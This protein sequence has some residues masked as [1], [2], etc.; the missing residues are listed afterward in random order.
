MVAIENRNSFLKQNSTNREVIILQLA[1]S[2]VQISNNSFLCYPG[3]IRSP[4]VF[5]RHAWKCYSLQSKLNMIYAF[6]K[7]KGDYL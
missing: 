1:V 5:W 2:A 4:E 3:I 6:W 7:N